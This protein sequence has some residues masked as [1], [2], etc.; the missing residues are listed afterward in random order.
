MEDSSY[1][2]IYTGVYIFIFIIALTG[3]IYLFTSVGTLAEKAYEFGNVKSDK[4]IIENIP[5]DNVIT[6]SPSEV[7]SYY[8]NYVQKD[9]YSV[10]SADNMTNRYNL[11]ITGRHGALASTLNYEQ[12]K[13]AIGTGEYVLRYESENVD[14]KGKKI[15]RVTITPKS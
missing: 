11:T 13:D 7:I 10:S 6:L 5:V 12:A 15:A 9:M 3:T 2:S 8:F 1:E 4:A 14:A